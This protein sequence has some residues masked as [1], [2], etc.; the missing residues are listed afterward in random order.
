VRKE[1]AI[2]ERMK[3]KKRKTC[4][5]KMLLCSTCNAMGIVS[6]LLGLKSMWRILIYLTIRI[7]ENTSG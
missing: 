1:T 4:H 7:A 5:L 3:E 6:T 2:K